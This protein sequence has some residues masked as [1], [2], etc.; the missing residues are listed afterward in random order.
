MLSGV[1]ATTLALVVI[2]VISFATAGPKSA[3][4]CVNVTIPRIHRR[5]GVSRLRRRGPRHL[6]R[7]AVTRRVAVAR[8]RTPDALAACHMHGIPVNWWI[9]LS[10]QAR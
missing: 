2:V 10:L 7:S 8:G 4:G 9:A 1:L 5:P 3:S 6:S